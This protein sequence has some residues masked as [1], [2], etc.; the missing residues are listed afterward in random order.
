LTARGVPVRVGSRSGSPRF[1]WHDDTTWASVLE[2]V[3]A[4]YLVYYPDLVAPGA[5]DTV[6]R[7]AQ[8][9]VTSGARRLVLL[10]GRG[11]EQAL[12]TEKVLMESGAT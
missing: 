3:S 2:Q 4:A 5:V 9:A 1:D 8:Q 11:E 12:R 7:F 6:Q 10:S